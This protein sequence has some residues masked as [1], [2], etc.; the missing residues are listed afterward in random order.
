MKN[1]FYLKILLAI[2]LHTAYLSAQEASYRNIN[3]N[4][5][6]PSSEVYSIIQDSK[7][8][9]WLSTDAGVCRFNGRKF[10]CFTTADGLKDN[11]VFN[12]F[13]D[14]KGRIWMI[15]FNGAVCYYENGK[16]SSIPASDSLMKKLKN[17]VWF[18]YS[19]AIDTGDTLWL[20]TNNGL[21]K[22]PSAENFK[23]VITDTSFEDSASRVIKV[24]KN[25]NT[26]VSSI[27]TNRD[28]SMKVKFN[29]STFSSLIQCKGEYRFTHR[30]YKESVFTSSPLLR[31]IYLKDNRLLFSNLND[32]YIS[33][34]G[35]PL[36]KKTFANNI[37][38]L[39]QDRNNDLWIGFSLG[40]AYKYSG[41]DLN[42]LPVKYF[43]NTSISSVLTDHEGG[44]W[45]STLE[46][47]VYYVPI[48][49]YSTYQNNSFFNGKINGLDAFKD[50]VFISNNKSQ[51]LIINS[52]NTV[53]LLRTKDVLN[54]S[55]ST[56]FYNYNN[57]IF[58][59]GSAIGKID[60]IKKT[61]DFFYNSSGTRATGIALVCLSGDD[62]YLVLG[63]NSTY[64]LKN[65]LALT[66]V[67]SKTRET[68]NP[69]LATCMIKTNKDLIYLGTRNGL[70][71]YS[72]EKFIPEFSGAT[73][74][75][76][77]NSTTTRSA[78]STSRPR[79]ASTRR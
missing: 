31:C 38:F 40:G 71:K 22:I 70:Y 74:C 78:R 53:D 46:N 42:L 50:K 24:F 49:N 44:I 36:Q 13:E 25:K 48:S 1:K 63:G 66:G 45:F 15:C 39:H 59:V 29:K 33:S 21:L 64:M 34:S 77:A 27:N 54:A 2:F 47:G 11:T 52:N 3:V 5:G 14:R 51:V 57:K 30:I 17:G 75:P 10:T 73:T 79:A 61:L 55:R 12:L 58:M 19:S 68:F 18:I 67:L 32:L 6:L 35:E 9:I 69:A 28:F 37:I 56:K 62:L 26:V 23:H 7:G 65:E 20:G 72:E 41:G 4:E 43:S 8:Y 76:S 16:I 60:T